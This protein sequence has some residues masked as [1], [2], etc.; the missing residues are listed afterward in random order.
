MTTPAGTIQ[1]IKL[2]TLPDWVGYVYVHAP[3]EVY[4]AVAQVGVPEENYNWTRVADEN[5]GR[6]K[7]QNSLNHIFATIQQQQAAA[8]QAAM[9]QQQAEFAAQEAALRQQM[10]AEER[11][12]PKNQPGFFASI[13]QAIREERKVSK[14]RNRYYKA[15]QRYPCPSCR[16]KSGQRC[17]SMQGNNPLPVPHKS[18]IQQYETMQG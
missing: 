5:D 18:R 3:G 15:V 10:L 2:H 16:A 11:Q 14:A 9:A 7:V 4:A 1:Q 6:A 13:G 12:N 8:Q 17:F